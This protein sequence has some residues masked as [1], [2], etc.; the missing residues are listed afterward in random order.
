M[1]VGLIAAAC[2]GDDD[3]GSGQGGLKNED[4]DLAED[5][6]TGGELRIASTSDVDYMDPASMYYTLSWFLGRGVFRT[7]VTYPGNVTDLAAQNELVPDLATGLGESNEDF[8][9]WTYTIKDG[10]T[11]GQAL[12][13]DDVPGV[14]G[15][16][17]VC[18]DFKYGIERMFIPSVGG[19]YPFY[20]DMIEGAS[21]FPDKADDV[22]GIE[23][24][25]D[26][27]I[28]FH[29]TESV[30]DW[31]FRMAMPASSPVPKAAAEKYDKKD[32][33]DYD[34]HVVATGPYYIAEWTPE[35]HIQLE[36]NEHWSK[37]TDDVRGAYVDSVDWQMGYDNDVGVQKVIDNEEDYG[38]DVSPLGPT[39]EKVVNDPALSARF[40]NE[41]EGCMRYIFMNTTIEPFD[42]Q[43]VREAVNFAIDRSNLKR[44]EGGPTTG[45]I[46][47][48]IIPP[49][50][51]GYVAPEEFNPFETPDMAGDYEKAKQLMAEA[52][53]PDGYDKP[54]NLVGASDP[55]HDKYLESARADLE[56]IGFTNLKVK[57]PAF[58]NQYTQFY[59]VPDSETAI[60]TSAGWCKDY[61]SAV[62]FL[63]PL[64]H[65]DNILDS[66]NSNYAEIDD[67]QLNQLIDDAIGSPP[68][69]EQTAAWQ[70]ANKYA[71]ETAV[72]VPWTW[73]NVTQL[74]S[75]RVVNAYYFS[76]TAGIDWPNVGIDEAAG[77]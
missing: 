46:A 14:T 50:I 77:E 41:P 69:E 54:L 58:P 56:A 27:T 71:T 62:T 30:G 21:D 45:P 15:E 33:S 42:N 2:G 47:T 43:Q 44:L 73:D 1:V 8:T 38:L 49:G 20:Y 6:P 9:E 7:L 48:S 70:E 3:G 63:D 23:C 67:P 52:G 28:T 64:F 26:K 51:D 31:N 66:G 5:V 61:N 53:Y 72:W 39:L 40:L 4:I 74:F 75:E 59:S 19:G 68:G 32:D 65:G 11:Y 55:P 22:S 76:F 34:K 36:R 16:E 29:L 37:D 17:I 10:V 60:G 13:G 57:T 18:E 12:G 25:D 35:E 24:V